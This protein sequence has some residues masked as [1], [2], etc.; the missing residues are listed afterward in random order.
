M[1]FELKGKK[2]LVTGGTKGIGRAIV[3]TLAGEGCDIA[4]CSRNADQVGALVEQLKDRGVNACGS[5][6]DVTDENALKDFVT[7]SA[8]QLG[9]LDIVVSNVGAMATGPDRDA[10]MKNLE[11]DVFGLLAL[12]ESS[13]ALLELAAAE[14][15]DASV[16]AI[17]STASVAALNA[18]SYG[19]VKAALV[20]YTKGLAKRYAGRKIRCNVVSPGM[21]YFQGGVWDRVKA[22]KPEVYKAQLARNPMGRMG[23]PQDIANAVAFLASPRAE[24]ITGINLIV[25][26][27]MTDRVNF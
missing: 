17:G 14:N 23:R 24:F 19:P 5:A 13:E 8:E 20:H 12:V 6:V 1:D 10:W 2:A 27:A 4:T 18:S 16:I 11:M 22:N 7:A 15:G 25:D 3:E 9:G 26:G 21:V